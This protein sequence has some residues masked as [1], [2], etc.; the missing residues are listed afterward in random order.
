MKALSNYANTKKLVLVILTFVVVSW[1][2]GFL[3]GQTL[4]RP[5][6]WVDCE[7]MNGIVTPASFDSAN[8]SFGEI[9]VGGAGFLGG[10][11][12][13]ADTGPGDENYRGP[14]WSLNSLRPDVD[15][16]KYAG[17]CSVFDLDLVDFAPNNQFIVIALHPRRGN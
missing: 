14:R 1:L 2:P 8:D 13:I 10:V 16:F 5:N 3:Y 12:V 9:Y 7:L 17:A 15:P 4:P 6:V 11:Q